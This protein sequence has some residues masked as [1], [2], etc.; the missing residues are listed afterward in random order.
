MRSFFEFARVIVNEALRQKRERESSQL[1]QLMKHEAPNTIA[2]IIKPI[3]TIASTNVGIETVEEVGERHGVGLMKEHPELCDKFVRTYLQYAEEL[4]QR[5][6]KR[7]GLSTK[8]HR[9]A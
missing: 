8:T 5:D 1:L 2:L 7:R 6:R 4:V 3:M 9:D